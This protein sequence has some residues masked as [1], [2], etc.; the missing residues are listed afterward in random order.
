[1]PSFISIGS[2]VSAPQGVHVTISHRLGEWFLQQCYALTCYT[3]TRKPTSADKG[4]PRVHMS[5]IEDVGQRNLLSS[6]RHRHQFPPG[7]W[8]RTRPPM[9]PGR[10]QTPVDRPSFGKVKKS[11]TDDS[12][13]SPD[14]LVIAFH[15]S[16]LDIKQICFPGCIYGGLTLQIQC[17]HG[18]CAPSF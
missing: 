2:P 16:P 5:P 14:M 10:V 3:V 18:L 1:M 4:H 15:F 7:S 9:R 17:A 13:M 6:C 11:V 8:V 12:V